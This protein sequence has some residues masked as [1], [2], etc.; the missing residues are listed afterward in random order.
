MIT[1]GDFLNEIAVNPE[2]EIPTKSTGSNRG[3]SSII[4]KQDSFNIIPIRLGYDTYNVFK[5]Y[6]EPRYQLA[7]RLLD[8]RGD[9]VDWVVVKASNEEI[10]NLGELARHVIDNAPETMPGRPSYTNRDGEIRTA[11]A[12][13]ER[14]EDSMLSASKAGG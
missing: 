13:L 9:S 6:V 12:T 5:R 11:K 10:A 7:D 2:F 4:P 8:R 14:I 3:S 1:F